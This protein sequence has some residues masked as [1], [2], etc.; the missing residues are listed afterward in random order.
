MY[1]QLTP[2]E[3]TEMTQL[4]R[5]LQGAIIDRGG[6]ANKSAVEDLLVPLFAI[7]RSVAHDLLNTIEFHNFT[8]IRQAQIDQAW[9]NVLDAIESLDRAL[10]ALTKTPDHPRLDVSGARGCVIDARARL[11]RLPQKELP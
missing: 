4:A 3:L 10:E 1:R 2:D 6:M 9:A 11:L 5:R 7:D 8:P